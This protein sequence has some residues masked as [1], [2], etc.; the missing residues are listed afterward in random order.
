MSLPVLVSFEL[1]FCRWCMNVRVTVSQSKRDGVV[2]VF[3][4]VF[5]SR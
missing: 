1:S 3:H 5:P 2:S 4:S